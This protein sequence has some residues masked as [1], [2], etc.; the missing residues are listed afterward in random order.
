MSGSSPQEGFLI[1]SRRL[2][3]FSRSWEKKNSS[4]RERDLVCLWRK[5]ASHVLDCL[6]LGRTTEGFHT[7]EEVAF[8][9]TTAGYRNTISVT[10]GWAATP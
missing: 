2:E 4:V 6:P 5:L 9:Y 10:W 3:A 8:H 7:A 1:D